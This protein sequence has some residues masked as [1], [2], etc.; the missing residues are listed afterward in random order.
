MR[1][2]APLTAISIPRLAPSCPMMSEKSTVSLLRK[3]DTCSSLDNC[4][5]K[6]VFHTK[7]SLQ[8]SFSS[9]ILNTSPKVSTPKILRPW[10]SVASMADLKETGFSGGATM[11]GYLTFIVFASLLL[12][13]I[14]AK[15]LKIDSDTMVICQVSFICSPPF[16]PMIAASMKNREVLASGLAVGVV[17]YAA[18]NYLGFLI[19]QLLNLIG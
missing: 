12:Q 1:L 5:N 14:L 17:G 11:V 19:Y 10:H 9:R 2:C 18:G 13:V 8:S 3:G 4:P 15:L 6:G 16:V 7:R